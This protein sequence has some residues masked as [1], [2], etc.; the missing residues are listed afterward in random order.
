MV[1]ISTWNEEWNVYQHLVRCE[2]TC[3]RDAW[4]RP[5]ARPGKD[6]GI[7]SDLTTSAPASSLTPTTHPVSTFNLLLSLPCQ[8]Y[9]EPCSFLSPNALNIRGHP[10]LE[11][12]RIV[13]SVPPFIFALNKSARHSIERSAISQ[14]TV[15]NFLPTL[16]KF[17]EIKVSANFPNNISFRWN[18]KCVRC[19]RNCNYN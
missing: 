6:A 11:A 10:L 18:E 16:A 5:L 19:V 13:T 14:T 7:D 17:P 15:P 8:A 3:I 1:I 2:S 4:V 9:C 12:E